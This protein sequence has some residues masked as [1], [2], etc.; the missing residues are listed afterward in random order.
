MKL[1]LLVDID[2]RENASASE[3][4]DAFDE[5]IYQVA[6]AYGNMGSWK[7]IGDVA[8]SW[9]PMRDAR[10]VRAEGRSWQSAAMLTHNDNENIM[11]ER[12]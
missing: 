8:C 11:E 5:A 10:L 3:I 4:A 7:Y 2:L 1:Q 6:Y 9:Q 12:K